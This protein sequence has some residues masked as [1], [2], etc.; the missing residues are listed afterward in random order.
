M[1]NVIQFSYGFKRLFSI[2][3]VTMLVLCMVVSY[4]YAELDHVLEAQAASDFDKMSEVGADN[5]ND[6]FMPVLD[7]MA[8]M[9]FAFE[10]YRKEAINAT[11]AAMGDSGITAEER[12]RKQNEHDTKFAPWIEKVDQFG[13][14]YQS[15]GTDTMT[16]ITEITQASKL[17]HE[18][19]LKNYERKLDE[20]GLTKLNATLYTHYN[21]AADNHAKLHGNHLSEYL[22]NEKVAHHFTPVITAQTVINNLRSK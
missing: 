10:S 16:Q 12:L 17:N 13:K 11:T 21:Q 2:I 7:K 3:M 6:H 9:T 15:Y 4:S 5:H 1:N 20:D 22:N 14:L 18:E 19:A 8:E